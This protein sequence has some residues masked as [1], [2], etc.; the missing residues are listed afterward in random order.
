MRTWLVV[1]LVVGLLAPEAGAAGPKWRVRHTGQ[2]NLNEATQEQ[3]DALPGVGLQAAQ[4]ILA[5]R[6]KRPFKR[7][8][9]LVRVKGFGRKR[10]LRLKP[11]LTLQG[12]TTLQAERMP[13]PEAAAP[14]GG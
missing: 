3:L 11:Y 6:Q 14:D 5:W 8:E 10:F 13:A 9:E 4:R 1:L 7:V 12:A 2:V